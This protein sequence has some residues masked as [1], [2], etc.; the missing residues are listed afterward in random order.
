[1]KIKRTLICDGGGMKGAFLAGVMAGMRDNGIN[2]TFFDN[3]V[4][5]SAGACSIAYFLTSQIDEGLRIWRNGLMK[6]FIKW[7]GFKPQL[8]FNYLRKILTEI[9]PLNIKVLKQ[10]KQKAYI[11]LTNVKKDRTD[12][13]LLNQKLDPIEILMASVGMPTFCP[14]KKINDQFYYDGGL[15]SEPP[16]D[17]ADSLKQDEIWVILN[18]PLNYR[19]T[20][21]G[22]KLL[23]LG[24]K[25]KIAKQLIA[26]K[27]AKINKILEDL[28]KRKDLII[29]CPKQKLPV[30]WMTTNKDDILKTINLGKK[31]TKEVLK[32][33][34]IIR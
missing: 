31:A 29:I 9:E 3:Y 21:L 26:E 32:K 27:P 24:V 11:A 6:D 14:P 19:V 33:R 18:R 15:T 20:T 4:G 7:K 34:K 13:I 17:F 23:S 12:Y 16:L 5:T 1:M 2:Y 8:D 22:W 30:N 28:E 25:N 10:R